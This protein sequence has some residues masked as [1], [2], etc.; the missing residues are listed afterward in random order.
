MLQ[1]FLRN[2][3]DGFLGAITGKETA[4]LLSLKKK[5]VYLDQKLSGKKKYRNKDRVRYIP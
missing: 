4:M 5:K 2:E 1:A 3:K